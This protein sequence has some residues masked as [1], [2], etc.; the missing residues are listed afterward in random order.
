[1]IRVLQKAPEFTLPAVVGNGD[2]KDVSLADYRG[3]F[4]VLFFYPL[5]FTFVCPTEI[6]EF[7]KREAEFKGLNAQVLGCSVDSKFSHKAWIQNGLGQLTYPLM[8][9]FNKEVARKYGALL[10]EQGVATRATFIIDPNGVLQYANYH[11]TDVGRSV[12]ETLRVLQA[13]QTGE[14]CPAEWKP[15]AKTLGK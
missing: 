13:I 11:N 6:Q 5:D 7:S 1:M 15:G 10:E 4:V 12:S 9:D 3:K 8:S 14:R 2:F